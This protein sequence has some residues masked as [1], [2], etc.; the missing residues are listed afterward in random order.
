MSDQRLVA[1]FIA[2]SVGISIGSVCSILTENLLM[3][4]VSA[5]WVPRMLSDGQKGNRVKA[6][7][8]GLLRLFHE[9]QN[10]FIS[11]F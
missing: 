4:M 3:E 1:C 10:Y 2:E 6:S 11:Q 5:W 9:H 7:T 8:K